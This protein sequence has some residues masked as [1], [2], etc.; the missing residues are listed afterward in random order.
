M[1]R[2]IELGGGVAMQSGGVGAAWALCLLSL[3]V[4]PVCGVGCGV[5]VGGVCVLWRA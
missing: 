5:G 3:P 4:C 2:G 1:K